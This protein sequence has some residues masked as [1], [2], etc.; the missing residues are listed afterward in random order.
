MVLGENSAGPGWRSRAVVGW[1]WVQAGPSTQAGGSGIDGDKVIEL[2]NK[3]TRVHTCSK[4][5]GGAA[6]GAQWAPLLS[7]VATFS[8]FQQRSG[9]QA[10]GTDRPGLTPFCHFILARSL[11][12]SFLL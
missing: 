9:S 7:P 3:I 1:Q 5:S 11:S 12:L 6:A 10:L 4:L 2:I 8:P